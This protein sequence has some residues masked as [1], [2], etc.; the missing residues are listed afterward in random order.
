MK[1]KKI[2]ASLFM[3]SAFLIPATAMAAEAPDVGVQ[4]NGVQLQFNDE[5]PVIKNNRVFLPLKTVFNG[6]DAEFSFDESENTISAERDGVKIQM[7]VGDRVIEATKEGSTETIE[8]D[9]A[10]FIENGHAYIPVRFVAQAFGCEVGWDRENTSVIIVDMPT[11]VGEAPTFNIINRYIADSKSLSNKKYAI[12]GKMDLDAIVNI[13]NEKFPFSA[14]YKINGLADKS[15][16]NMNTVM[17]LDFSSLKKAYS[18]ELQKPYSSKLFSSFEDVAI[19]Y[20]FDMST[21]SLYIQGSLLSYIFGKSEDTWYYIKFDPLMKNIG[22][23]YSEVISAAENFNDFGEYANSMLDKISMNSIYINEN[24]ISS[25]KIIRDVYSDSAFRE[26]DGWYVSR[27]RDE[28]GPVSIAISLEIPVEA[29]KTDYKIS[30]RSAIVGAYEGEN[31]FS[32]E[33]EQENLATDFSM[34]FNIDEHITMN[35][36]GDIVYSETDQWPV[37]APSIGSKIISL[38]ENSGA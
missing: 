7:T 34:K 28:F 33:I 8:T 11:L 19:N 27:Y 4:L 14:K 26:K 1:L 29:G 17:N 9:A 30:A 36:E 18:S 24:V 25:Y 32:M 15:K 6:I 2:I 20:I 13:E 31:I 10:S 21:G 5:K 23:S 3:T 35:V 22:M 16:I 37:V 12:E 38:N